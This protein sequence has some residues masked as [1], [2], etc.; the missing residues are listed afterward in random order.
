M[1]WVHK[2]NFPTDDPKLNPF[3]AGTAADVFLL[4]H[5]ERALR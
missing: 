3:V 1:Q 5:S 4:S 2:E